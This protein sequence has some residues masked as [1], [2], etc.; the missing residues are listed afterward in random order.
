MTPRQL[1]QVYRRRFGI[2]TSYRLM[3]TMRARTSSTAVT[4]R[5]F[6]VALALLVKRQLDVHISDN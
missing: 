5:L 6:Y 3:N 4:L 1:F 2:E